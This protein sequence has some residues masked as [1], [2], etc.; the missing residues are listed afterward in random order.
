MYYNI[1]RVNAYSDSSECVI[2]D[3]CPIDYIAYSQYTAN[4]QT[5]DIDDAFVQM[6]V[7]AVRQSL[8]HLDWLVFFDWWPMEM[9]DEWDPSD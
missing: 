4:Y 2:F 5:T 9:E 6:M 3:R 7:P 8:Q 1:S